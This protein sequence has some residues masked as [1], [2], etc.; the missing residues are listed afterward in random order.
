MSL[1]GNNV[2]LWGIMAFPVL[3]LLK[4]ETEQALS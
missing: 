1:L 4:E 3:L 2:P